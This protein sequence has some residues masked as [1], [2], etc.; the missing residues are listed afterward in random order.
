LYIQV[1]FIILEPPTHRVGKMRTKFDNASQV[2][3]VDQITHKAS[4][5]DQEG[6]AINIVL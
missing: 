5:S 3:I 6:E 4:L 2:N 1:A